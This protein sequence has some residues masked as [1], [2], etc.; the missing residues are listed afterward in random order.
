MGR[1][2]FMG[3]IGPS[4]SAGQPKRRKCGKQNPEKIPKI[5]PRTAREAPKRAPRRPRRASRR[6]KRVPNGLRGLPEGPE[7]FPK[8]PQEGHRR[9]PEVPKR[10]P[11]GPETAQARQDG[12]R[13]SQDGPRGPQD[14]PKE[15]QK[16]PLEGLEMQYSVISA[17]L[18]AWFLYVVP[19]PSHQQ[20]SK[21]LSRRPRALTA[22]TR[23][24]RPSAKQVNRGRRMTE[25]ALASRS[26]S[27]EK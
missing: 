21:T 9:S 14:D 5:A 1:T 23:A 18:L 24:F 22:R 25:S 16:D 2:G 27:R 12:P 11:E 19:K 20:C 26:V 4:W 17:R 10:A 15:P 8:E 3:S 13:V 6:P 7:G